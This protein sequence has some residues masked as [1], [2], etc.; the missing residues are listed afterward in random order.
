VTTS[1]SQLE[2][3]LRRYAAPLSKL[4]QRICWVVLI[5]AVLETGFFVFQAGFAYYQIFTNVLLFGGAFFA[6]GVL[7]TGSFSD[8]DGYHFKWD[9]GFYQQ[10]YRGFSLIYG[11]FMFLCLMLHLQES[12]RLHNKV[13]LLVLLR[14]ALF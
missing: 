12:A 1:Q 6:Y 10:F 2:R 11:V 7:K 13:T 4:D 3:T 8:G 14:R 9:R 5:L